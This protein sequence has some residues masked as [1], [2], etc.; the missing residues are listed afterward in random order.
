[1]AKQNE[2]VN[3][4]LAIVAIYAVWGL[5]YG[6]F[7]FVILVGAIVQMLTKSMPA[8][9]LIGTVVAFSQNQKF[10]LMFMDSRMAAARK[11]LLDLEATAATEGFQARD[12]KSIADRIEV[13]HTGAPLQPKVSSPTG[14]LESPS[15]LDNVPLKPMQELTSDAQP[16]ASIPASAKARVLI[17]PVPESF[18]PAPQA[19]QDHTPMENPYLQ[20]GPDD[21]GVSAALLNK[22][23]DIP[24][25]VAANDVQGMTAEA[26]AF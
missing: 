16:G 12:P 6:S 26:P 13:S 17:Y 7:L 19:S 24:V 8:A 22:G 1:M 14:V 15:I 20:N 10:A 3:A 21:M 11:N 18:V 4:L 9:L 23:T 2:M 25:E 5:S